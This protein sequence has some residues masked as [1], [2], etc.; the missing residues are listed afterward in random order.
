MSAHSVAACSPALNEATGS[1]PE[2]S[3]CNSVFSLVW[4]PL[5]A[6]WIAPMTSPLP[7]GRPAGFGLR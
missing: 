2:A 7:A 1:P 6:A 5:R 3:S 4:S